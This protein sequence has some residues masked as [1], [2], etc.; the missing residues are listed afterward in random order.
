MHLTLIWTGQFV[1]SE[2]AVIKGML[3]GIINKSGE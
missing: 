1:H 2:I 3:T